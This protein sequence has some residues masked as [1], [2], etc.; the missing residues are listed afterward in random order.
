M[1]YIISCISYAGYHPPSRVTQQIAARHYYRPFD[2]PTLAVNA[3][4]FP[5]IPL[6]KI[7]E[8]FGGWAAAQRTHFADGGIFDQINVRTRE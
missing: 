6:I 8:V 5:N 1:I 3:Q 7:D 4:R 2:A